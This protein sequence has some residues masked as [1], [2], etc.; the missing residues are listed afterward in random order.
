MVAGASRAVETG[1]LWCMWGEDRAGF[2]VRVNE[3]GE[4]EEC[5]RIARVKW[6]RNCK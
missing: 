2:E 4:R 3:L 6:A 5:K 1:L